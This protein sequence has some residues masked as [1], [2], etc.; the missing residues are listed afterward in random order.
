MDISTKLASHFRQVYFGKNWTASQ[1]QAHLIGVSYAQATQ[2]IYGCNSIL[3]LAYHSH[4]YVQMVTRVLEGGPLE[5][6]DETSFLHPHIKTEAD[7]ETFRDALWT[8]GEKF[9]TLIEQIPEEKFD[10]VFVDK[11]YGTWFRAI[12]GIIEHTHY[13]LGQIVML[14]KILA[15][16][17]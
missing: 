10:E 11:N 1:F 12:Q 4:Y 3:T 7:W 15:Q 14:K 2:E 16:I 9:A 13:H 5:G 6:N 17:P 8:E